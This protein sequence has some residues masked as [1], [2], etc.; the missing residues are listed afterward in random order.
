MVSWLVFYRIQKSCLPSLDM[1]T[2]KSS[3]D[4]D[5]PL[6]VISGFSISNFKSG[7]TLFIIWWKWSAVSSLVVL[8]GVLKRGP[9]PPAHLDRGSKSREVQIR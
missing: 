4:N 3:N 7:C 2:L 6:D 1:V 9:N 8:R 5:R